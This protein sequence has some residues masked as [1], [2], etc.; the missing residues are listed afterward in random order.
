[1]AY[2][3]AQDGLAG[4]AETEAWRELVAELAGDLPIEFLMAWI[5]RESDGNACSYTSAHESGLFQLMPPDN[6]NVAGTTEAELRTACSG[7]SQHL[8]RPFTD[9]EN[10]TN[11]TKQ[12][13]YVNHCREVAHE[14]LSAAGVDWDDET[15]PD[16]WKFVKLQHAYPSPTAGWLAAAAAELGRPAASWDEFASFVPSHASGVMRNAAAVGGAADPS[17]TLSKIGTVIVMLVLVVGAC[18]LAS[19]GDFPAV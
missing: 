13:V 12:L 10:R 3:G 11:I 19:R 17:S 6:T 8:A 18:Y 15:D 4:T 7:S 14:K 2:G 16:F 9:D 1:M 5:R